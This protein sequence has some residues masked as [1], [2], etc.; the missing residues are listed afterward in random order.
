MTRVFT[1]IAGKVW[2]QY[3]L[4]FFF[5]A[6][7]FFPARSFC[8]DDFY[9]KGLNLLK[10]QQY[11]EAIRAF[12]KA[13]EIIPHDYEAYNNRGT[14]WFFKGDHERAIA[15]FTKALEMNPKFA[16]AFC[17]RGAT[18]FHTGDYG[19]AIA[20][21]T[22]T[23][24][25]DPNYSKAYYQ[26]AMIMVICP[27]KRYRNP[28][29]AI[30]LAQ[31]AVQLA[32]TEIHLDVLAMAYAATDQY[33][34][35]AATMEELISLSQNK[36]KT[37]RIEEYMARL[38]AYKEHGDLIEKMDELEQEPEL[39]ALSGKNV[40]NVDTEFKPALKEDVIEEAELLVEDEVRSDINPVPPAPV[41][42]SPSP[43]T[44]Q[45]G[46]FQDKDKAI[47]LSTKL[48]EEGRPCFTS[49]TKIPDRGD[50]YRVFIG[51]YETR[52]EAHE[53]FIKLREDEF[54][55]AFIAKKP[56]AIQVKLSDTS[57]DIQKLEADFR[58]LG[59]LSYRFQGYRH[60]PEV[61]I[62]IGAFTTASDAALLI[63]TLQKQGL[64][65]KA[66]LR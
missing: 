1:H 23:L 49:H 41:K 58:S 32:H 4:L 21:L 12:S 3:V 56:Y 26:L 33:G 10:S 66:A 54:S 14:A 29:N 39:I 59:Y 60:N 6:Y 36:G 5:V 8:L 52:E 31:K 25:I 51:E 35:A 19:Q 16:G 2:R 61:S 62:L 57:L 37:G 18:W 34:N 15:D 42:K 20:D 43:Y 50:F 13:I 27:D 11:D 48:I 44:I 64:A 30:T 22:K 9:E 53:V 7:L 47:Q 55:I 40:E 24:D 45:V 65:S 63:E 38:N 46:A 17:N 28:T